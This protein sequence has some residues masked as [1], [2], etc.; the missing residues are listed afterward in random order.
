MTEK[1]IERVKQK[2]K[3]IKSALASD[4][5]RWGGFYDDS[6]GLRYLPPQYYIKIKDYR[7]GNRYLNWFAKNF[8]SDIGLPD[9]LFESIIIRFYAKKIKE[10]KKAAL[11]TFCSNTYLF[12]K[13]FGMPVVQID[14]YEGS[15]LEGIEFLEYFTYSSEQPELSEFSEWLKHLIADE[16]F[17]TLCTDYIDISIELQNTRDVT[18]RKELIQKKRIIEEHSFSR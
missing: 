4:K 16:T 9:F 2:I 10:A 6:S 14:K 12:D 15:N 3:K 5:K 18:R 11:N 17:E 13:Y 7:S 8:P 1:Q